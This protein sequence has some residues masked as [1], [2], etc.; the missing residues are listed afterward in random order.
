MHG[1]AAWVDRVIAALFVM[2][3]GVYA[4]RPDVDLWDE[5]RDARL[6]PGP[7]PVVAHPPCERWG[8][9]A[10]SAGNRV[11]DDAGCFASALASV[12]I[13]GG[14]LEHPAGS[15]A[16]G[17]FNLRRPPTSGGWVVADGIG[18]TCC[19]YQ[20]RYGHRAPKATWLYAVRTTL[21][22]LEWGPTEPR[23]LSHLPEAE[24]RRAI[25]TGICQR[26]SR[27]QRAATPP[28]FADLLLGL[29]GSCLLESA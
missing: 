20:G 19:V 23:D 8:R 7:W 4:N 11:G 5:A 26:L 25:K 9:F 13:H 1:Y 15:L 3:N 21:P 28:A 16:W 29:A 17:H 2:R 12:R 22:T 14:V 10:T 18:Y 24:R 27:K 6:Y